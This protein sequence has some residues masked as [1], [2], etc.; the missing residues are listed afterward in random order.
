MATTAIFGSAGSVQA[1]TR[2][3]ESIEA[4]NPELN[5]MLTVTSEMALDEARAAD[6]AE[7]HGEWLG[8]LQGVPV[9]VKDCMDRAGVRTTYGSHASVATVATQDATV[10]RR[11]R[12]AGSVFLGKNN[13]HEWCFGGTTQNEHFGPCRNPWD[14]AR[15]PGGSSGGSGAAVAAGMCRVSLGTDTGGSVRIPAA[16]CGVSGLRPTVGSV[17]NTGV[18]EVSVGFDTVGPLA[19]DV[20]DVARTFVAIAGYDPRDPISAPH[21]YGDVLAGMRDGIAGV[22]VGV[23]RRFFFDDVQPD[24]AQR[25]L[26][27]TRELEACGATIVEIELS[28][29]DRAH[30]D[31]AFTITV[32][33]MAARHRERIEN[34]PETIGP[35]TL[36]RMQ[37][38]LAVSGV[39]YAAASRRLGEWKAQLRKIFASVDLIAT[40]TCPMVAPKI[41]AAA[42]M[43]ETTRGLT[44]FTFAF[45]QAGLPATSVPCGF[46]RDGMPVGFQLIAPWFAEAL[47]FRAGVAYQSRTEFHRARPGRFLR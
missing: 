27:A 3:L 28:G 42:D 46:D 31:A 33:D 23:P 11:L 14:P 30:Q 22:R 8:L 37:L 43:I 4:L 16:M 1:T 36:R 13:L 29:A 10:V 32:A 20:S 19:Y 35:E 9:S 18:V 25:V 5:A 17:P 39:D 24:V 45:G 15:I 34:A 21:A 38:G 26:E 7:E 6:A 47:L 41:A 44:R 2:A 40:P 12:A